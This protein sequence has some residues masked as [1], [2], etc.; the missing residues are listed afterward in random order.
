M[1]RF[2][3]LIPALSLFFYSSENFAQTNESPL[4]IFGYFQN[5]FIHQTGFDAEIDSDPERNSFS[6]QQLNL[7]FQKDLAPSWR[8]FVNFEFLNNFSSNRQW[9]AANLEEAWVRYGSDA[10]FNLKFGLLIPTFNNL[11][12]IK[13][14]TPLLP[15][16]IRPIAYETSFGEFIAVEEH[17]PARAFLQ[18]Y[19]F[20]PL[21]ELKFDYAFFLGNSPNINNDRNIGQ[22]GVDST[23]TFLIGG[24][25]GVRTG[26]LKLGVSATRENVNGFPQLDIIEGNPP[27]V[28]KE[29]PRTRLGGDFSFYV[30]GLSLEAEFVLTSY[31]D[32]LPQV[33]LDKQFYYATLG[34][35]FTDE[36]F[37]YGSYWVVEEDFTRNF[38]VEDLP[39]ECNLTDPM[40]LTGVSDIIVP[41]FGL[42]YNLNDRIT[43]KAQFALVDVDAEIPALRCK[44]QFEFNHY[45]I[46][47]SVF[48]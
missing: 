37:I 28:F 25:V 2:Y 10:K 23:D 45:S 46:A 34:Y 3:L 12:E 16:I 48:F 13:N 8:A 17:L 7:F 29:V 41:T 35:R 43:F 20:L 6:V 9:G 44:Q 22:T 21:D 42:A 11:N 1:T 26:E 4:R 19:G 15:Y 39:P 31:D 36:L 14:R 24:R 5:S 30:G 18:A 32:D 40:L 47:A 27:A 33:S 38:N